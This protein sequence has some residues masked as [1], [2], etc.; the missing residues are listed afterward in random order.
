MPGRGAALENLDDDHASAAAWARVR[1]GGRLVAIIIIGICSLA[2][3]LLGTEQLAGACD[4]FSAG[5]VGE[6]TIMADAVKAVGQD[7]QQEAADELVRIEGHDAVAGLAFAP[8]IFVFEADTLAIEGD[9]AGIGDGDAVGIAG[10]IGEHGIGT[11][12]GTLGIDNPLHGRRGLRNSRNAS[13][14]LSA[15][16]APK[17]CSA[18]LAWAAASRSHMSRRNNRE[19]TLTQRK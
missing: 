18:P 16:L 2:L 17:N 6:Q 12:E 5:R 9:E 10:E 8:V 7:V 11:G 13:Q 3:G 4:I 15:V 19:S 1:E 14:S